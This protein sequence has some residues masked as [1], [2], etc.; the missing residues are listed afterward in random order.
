MF[1]GVRMSEYRRQAEPVD[2]DLCHPGAERH[3]DRDGRRVAI[4]SQ[5]YQ[6]MVL[7]HRPVPRAVREITRN[8]GVTIDSQL[9]SRGLVGQAHLT[10]QALA[11]FDSLDL[12]KA[13]QSAAQGSH[14]TGRAV[15]GRR[16][17][18]HGTVAVPEHTSLVAE[19]QQGLV[20]QHRRTGT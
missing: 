2:E 12:V 3:R 4:E 1:G 16:K 9:G 11:G 14:H 10:R 19:Q 6:T 18:V 17:Q 7:D 13:Q 15:R 5:L 20:G 8:R